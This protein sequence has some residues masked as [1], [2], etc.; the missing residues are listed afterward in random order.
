M[1]FHQAE[2]IPSFIY[3]GRFWDGRDSISQKDF[4]KRV[5]LRRGSNG[6]I[7]VVGAKI[8]EIPGIGNPPQVRPDIKLRI[9]IRLMI[10]II[11]PAS[12]RLLPVAALAFSTAAVSVTCL[13]SSHKIAARVLKDLLPAKYRNSTPSLNPLFPCTAKKN[14]ASIWGNRPEKG[15][16]MSIPSLSFEWLEEDLDC[17]LV[18]REKRAAY[19]KSANAPASTGRLHQSIPSSVTFHRTSGNFPVRP[20]SVTGQPPALL[21]K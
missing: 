7:I 12:V 5:Q 9:K 10:Q 20:V 13:L 17:R 18:L 2:V 1:P 8:S 3:P 21:I 19:R 16:S 4:P 14:V 11:R 15:V 6:Q